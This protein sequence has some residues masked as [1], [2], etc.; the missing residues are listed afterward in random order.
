MDITDQ[1]F[2]LARTVDHEIGTY[3][4]G[5]FGDGLRLF[6]EIQHGAGQQ[7]RNGAEI[8]VSHPGRRE[9]GN[10]VIFFGQRIAHHEI[11]GRGDQGLMGSDSAFGQT[12]GAGGIV[13]KGGI[14]SSFPSSTFSSNKPG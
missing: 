4:A 1:A 12:G 14:R 5:I 9:V 11:S 13:D 8:A 7:M 10:Q 6:R 3:F 2:P